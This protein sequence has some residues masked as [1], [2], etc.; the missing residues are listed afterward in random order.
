[1]WAVLD[2]QKGIQ[3]GVREPHKAGSGSSGQ[4]GKGK[5]QTRVEPRAYSAA[6]GPVQSWDYP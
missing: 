1:M 4:G 2:V 3:A 5:G 6:D